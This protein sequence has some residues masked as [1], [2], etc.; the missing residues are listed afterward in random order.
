MRMCKAASKKDNEIL[1]AHPASVVMCMKSPYLTVSIVAERSSGYDPPLV[2]A[3]SKLARTSWSLSHSLADLC[4]AFLDFDCL[5]PLDR[6]ALVAENI[7]KELQ[8]HFISLILSNNFDVCSNSE[9]ANA[10]IGA[11]NPEEL[12]RHV[13][14][15]TPH[16][17]SIFDEASNGLTAFLEK[18]R[19]S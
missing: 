8:G 14:T 2:Y 11:Q 19:V 1:T 5:A 4:D 15:V 12:A 17:S 16:L 10:R 13:L 6:L 18:G 9:N 3:L 7:V